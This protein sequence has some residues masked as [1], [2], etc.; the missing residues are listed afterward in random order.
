MVTNFMLQR[1]LSERDVKSRNFLFQPLLILP[2]DLHL[3]RVGGAGAPGLLE[4]SLL[5]W[6]IRRYQYYIRAADNNPDI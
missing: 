5:F 6:Q 3:L 4:L 2:V 1:N